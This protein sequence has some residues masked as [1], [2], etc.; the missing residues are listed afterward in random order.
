M[1]LFQ[2]VEIRFANLNPNKPSTRNPTPGDRG[3]WDITVITRDKKQKDEWEAEKLRVT[4][5]E[6]SEG[7]YYKA[8]M[9]RNVQK[10]DGTTSE[11]PNIVDGNLLKFD[12]SKIGAGTIA[13]IRTFPSDWSQVDEKTG[14]TMTGTTHILMGMQIVKYVPYKAKPREDDFAAIGDTEVV[15]LEDEL[16][17]DGFGVIPSVSF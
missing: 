6:D 17:D 1:S 8:S 16:D 7:V 14:K 2:N 9:K 12:A 3:R 11:F 4:L 10:K 5:K 13:N 15:H